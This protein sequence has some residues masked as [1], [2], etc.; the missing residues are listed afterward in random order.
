MFWTPCL[1]RGSRAP[2]PRALPR[3]LPDRC[4][5]RCLP[6]HPSTTPFTTSTAGTPP[7]ELAS[8][9]KAANSNILPLPS[10]GTLE[11]HTYGPTSGF[12][13]LYIH[14]TPD[15]GVTLSCF[16]T[17]LAS[18]LGVRWIAPDR[19][20]IGESTFYAD[21]SVLD[22]PADIRALIEHLGIRQF[23][24]MG[25]SGGSGYTLACARAFP[26]KMVNGV[27]NLRGHRT[28][29]GRVPGPKCAR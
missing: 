19:P 7:N 11:Y 27:G 20:G 17:C 1:I 18:R 8:H 26:R 24:I 22:Y 25:T 6:P 3:S 2:R 23:A 5:I 29:R 12:P 28:C 21:R 4:P 9:S 15:S 10:G 16:E 13:I 14:G